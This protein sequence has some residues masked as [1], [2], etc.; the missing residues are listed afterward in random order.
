M[1]DEN[2]VVFVCGPIGSGKTT[3]ANKN[4][5]H[6]TDLDFM[7][8]YSSKAD[9]I[10]L[11]LKL[12][13]KFKSVCHITCFPSEEELSA[14]LKY[15]NEFILLDTSLN[16]C[17]TNILIRGRDRDLKNINNVFKANENYICKYRES[18]I[19]WKKVKVFV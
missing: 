3:Y 10:N 13:K 4:Y 6:V 2:T 18:D 9:Q 16:Q 1:S 7:P 17:K 15:N 8:K 14:F 11:S 12:L 19:N 5:N